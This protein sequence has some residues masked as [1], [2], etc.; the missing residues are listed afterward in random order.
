MECPRRQHEN[1]SDSASA[2]RAGTSAIVVHGIVA[3]VRN[4]VLATAFSSSNK[5]YAGSATVHRRIID[6]NRSV[7]STVAVCRI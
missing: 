1:P 4:L 5:P 6:R 3:S 2:S 7:P